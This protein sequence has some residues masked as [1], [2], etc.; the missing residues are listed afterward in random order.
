MLLARRGSMKARAF[1]MF[2]D[3]KSAADVAARLGES[4]PLIQRY[5]QDYKKRKG[6]DEVHHPQ[7]GRMIHKVLAGRS[8]LSVYE[9]FGHKDDMS[10]GV[11][12]KAYSRYAG[13]MVSRS[14]KDGHYIPLLHAEL[15]ARRK[16]D[17]LDIDGYGGPEEA[18][19][20]GILRAIS[21]GGYLFVTWPS[22]MSYRFSVSHATAIIE[23][24]TDQPKAED[25]VRLILH[26]GVRAG[27]RCKLVDCR[28]YDRIFR[29]AF[30]VTDL[31]MDATSVELRMGAL[32]SIYSQES[33]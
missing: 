9:V 7:K 2:S 16:W 32:R 28:Y 29:A 17:V 4:T 30:E 22:T 6:S 14:K 33:T 26:E 18:L 20:T 23:Y 11:C 8:G 3:G 27:K 15:A 12:S 13:K 21:D 5:F 31:A 1:V 25:F 10:P 19:R 24:G